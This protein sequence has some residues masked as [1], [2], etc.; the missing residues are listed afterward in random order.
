MRINHVSINLATASYDGQVIV[1]NMV[2]GH[3]F[4]FLDAPS[5]PEYE[6]HHVSINLATASYD[7]QVIVWNMVSGHIFAFLDAPSPPEYEDQS[8]KYKSS[9][10]EL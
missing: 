9:H 4:A 8:C 10:S 2:S 1:W 6:D 7:G 3:I 5:P